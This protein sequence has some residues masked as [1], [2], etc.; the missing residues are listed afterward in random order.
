M[1]SSA[2]IGTFELVIMA[3]AAALLFGKHI[4]VMSGVIRRRFPEFC[5][6]WFGPDY[7]E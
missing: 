1:G 4:P 2:G 6:G 3:I 7:R 5:R